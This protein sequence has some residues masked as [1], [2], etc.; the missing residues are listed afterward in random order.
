METIE[1]R[2]I[3]TARGWI[4]TRFHHQGRLKAAPGHKGGVDCLGLLIGVARELEL[5]AADGTPLAAL[6]TADYG[7]LP[8]GEALKAALERHLLPADAPAPGCI[9]LLA[10]DGVAPRHLGIVGAIHHSPPTT[11]ALT[12]IHA[13]AQARRVVEHRLDAWWVERVRGVYRVG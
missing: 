3:T 13:Y 11:H 8:N 5:R 6:D 1:E 10:P 4:G 12:L 7:H 2:I 9:L